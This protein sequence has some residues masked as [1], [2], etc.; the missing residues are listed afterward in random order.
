M[1]AT[2]LIPNDYTLNRALPFF[3]CVVADCGP[4][5]LPENGKVATPDGTSYGAKARY[6]CKMGFELQGSEFRTC[7]RDGEWSPDAPICKR[8]RLC[9]VVIAKH[10]NATHCCLKS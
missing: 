8:R 6:S 7:Q 3:C 1:L 2:P 10:H 5:E 9:T 4:P